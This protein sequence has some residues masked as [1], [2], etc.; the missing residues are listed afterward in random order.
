[1]KKRISATIDEKTE[2][3]LNSLLKDGNYRNKSHVIETAIK[4]L[5]EKDD[6]KK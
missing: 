2:K 3:L 4:L 5:E 6:K 1:M